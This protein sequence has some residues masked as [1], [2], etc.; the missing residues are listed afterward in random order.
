[1]SLCFWFID[2]AFLAR[3]KAKAD[4]E[5]YTAQRA[6]EAN[7]VKTQ[8]RVTY[9]GWQMWAAKWPSMT[10]ILLLPLAAQANTR[11]PA[12]DEIQGHRSQQQNLLWER[13]TTD[14]CG[15]WL[16]RELH[17]GLRSHGH[18]CRA[19]HG[20]GLSRKVVAPAGLLKGRALSAEGV[21]SLQGNTSKLLLGIPVLQP[22]SRQHEHSLCP[23][24][25]WSPLDTVW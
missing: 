22:Q 11:V 5:F 24:G 2:G 23:D 21:A 6:A 7:K 17:Q 25:H 9:C 10:G 12:A 8:T 4:A 13:H 3:Q 18:C 15:L 19:H 20:P 1:M 14:V 16:S